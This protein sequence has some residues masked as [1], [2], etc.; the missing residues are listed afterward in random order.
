MVKLFSKPTQTQINQAKAEFAGSAT[1]L[2]YMGNPKY[3]VYTVL[4]Q[5]EWSYGH[6]RRRQFHEPIHTK[7]GH[8][9]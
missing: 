4:P 6:N 7:L 1:Q 3:V 2:P 5:F 8:F 9:L